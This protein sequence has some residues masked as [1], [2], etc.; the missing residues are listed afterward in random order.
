MFFAVKEVS[1]LD[2]GHNAQQCITQLEQ[3]CNHLLL[4]F[5][6]YYLNFFFS[7]ADGALNVPHYAMKGEI[8]FA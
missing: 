6:G 3:V 1:L 8:S 5:F 4:A 7:A 2:Q